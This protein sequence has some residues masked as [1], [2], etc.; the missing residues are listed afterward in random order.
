M[1]EVNSIPTTVN[2]LSQELLAVFPNPVE[3]IFQLEFSLPEKYLLEI[4][5]YNAA[6]QRIAT[7][8]NGE[9]KAGNNTFTFNKNELPAGTYFIMIKDANQNQ[10]ANEKII[11]G[12]G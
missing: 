7:L 10:L 4:A 3:D 6:S 2:L 12:R 5:I 11:I 9:A 8:F 1:V